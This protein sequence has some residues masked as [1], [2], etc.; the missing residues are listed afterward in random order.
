MDLMLQ[1]SNLSLSWVV[2]PPGRARK[3]NPSASKDGEAVVKLPAV[4]SPSKT[5][6]CMAKR[7]WATVIFQL[8]GGHWTVV[9][10]SVME[11]GLASQSRKPGLRRGQ[12]PHRSTAS[13]L[14]D[15]AGIC[16]AGFLLCSCWENRVPLASGCTVLKWWTS[17]TLVE[18][19]TPGGGWLSA[20]ETVS[21]EAL[22]GLVGMYS[23]RSLRG[24]LVGGRQGG[25]LASSVGLLPGTEAVYV[26]WSLMRTPGGGRQGGVASGLTLPN[27]STPCNLG[28][29]GSLDRTLLTRGTGCTAGGLDMA[30][31]CSGWAMG[32]LS[33]IFDLILCGVSHQRQS[34]GDVLLWLSWL[35]RLREW[36]ELG[37]EHG[38]IRGLFW[39]HPSSALLFWGG[40]STMEV[41][42][43]W[44]RCSLAPLV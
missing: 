43:P 42:T 4:W 36:R 5:M 37:V 11:M 30:I 35:V 38:G 23:S 16:L 44:W 13:S 9:T 21:A 40:H 27:P 8:Q 15:I 10:G 7:R 3:L 14:A 1:S 2:P 33:E 6:V 20:V 29:S 34:S 28:G 26:G 18:G 32:R 22:L 39:G 19:K 25:T 24:A 12:Q 41:D 31:S 17:G